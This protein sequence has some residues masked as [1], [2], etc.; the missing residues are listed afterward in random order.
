MC[1][2]RW[3]LTEGAYHKFAHHFQKELPIIIPTTT[4]VATA[5][6]LR[7]VLKYAHINKRRGSELFGNVVVSPQE[8]NTV[9]IY[10]KKNKRE[11]VPALSIFAL[12]VMLPSGQ[13]ASGFRASITDGKAALL[14]IKDSFP[15]YHIVALYDDV[16][17]F[18]K[19]GE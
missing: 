4:P 17:E 13:V 9:L 5:S 3:S 6:H 19:I 2:M 10:E 7:D 14:E 8:N 11:E 18:T 16:V 1:A 12:M 15:N